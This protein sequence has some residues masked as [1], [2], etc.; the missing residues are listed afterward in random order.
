MRSLIAE[1]VRQIQPGDALEHAHIAETLAWVE[2]GAPLFRVQKPDVPNK[3]LV[4]YFMLVDEAASKVLLVDHIKA[5]LWLPPG[6][7]VDVDEDPAQAARRECWE[8]L[9]IEAE[10]ISDAPFFV[11]STVTVGMTAGHT[12]VSL[13]YVLRGDHRVPLAFDASEFNAVQWFDYDALPYPRTDPHMHRFMDKW[14]SR[15][16]QALK[17]HN[18]FSL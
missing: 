13:W 16:S 6:G 1:K 10:F 15:A 17:P 11:T 3:H 8:E 9:Q 7:H 14:R 2:S 5:G 12:D 18:A 4:S